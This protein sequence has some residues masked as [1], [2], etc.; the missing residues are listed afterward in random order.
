M[1]EFC[2]IIYTYIGGTS[3]HIHGDP[4]HELRQA[5]ARAGIGRVSEEPALSLVALIAHP[6]ANAGGKLRIA[7][8]ADFRE[9]DTLRFRYL[10]G[11]LARVRLPRAKH[12]ERADGLWRHTC[13][14]AFI[15]A[16]DAAAY[17][18]LNFSPSGDWAVY[19]FT[20]YR[21]GMSSPEVDRPPHMLVRRLGEGLEVDAAVRLKDLAGLENA[22]RLQ[23]ALCAVIE[24]VDGTLSHWALRHPPHRADFHDPA[25]FALDLAIPRP[26]RPEP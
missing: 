21:A 5:G 10:I 12:P 8:H 18:E 11:D 7:A 6:T 25:G 15:R 20:D 17:H 14:E 2:K 22:P 9:P 16:P 26:A 13:V 4:A 19:R 3:E 24:E 1:L 23:I